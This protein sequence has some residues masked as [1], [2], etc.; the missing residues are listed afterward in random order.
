L[1]HEH[2][3]TNQ[4]PSSY[5]DQV[6]NHAIFGTELYSHCGVHLWGH[7]FEHI[8]L[9]KQLLPKRILVDLNL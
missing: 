1:V 6:L 5:L 3:P 7:D 9:L 4:T 2:K 8:Q